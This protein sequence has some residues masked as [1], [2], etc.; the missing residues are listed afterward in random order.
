M[1]TIDSLK[2]YGAD[3]NDG[4]TRCMNNESFY[5]MLVGKVLADK[6]LEQLEEQLGNKDYNGAFES[7]HALKGMYSNLSLTPLTKP[8]SEMTELLRN[9]TDTDYSELLKETKTQFE[10]LKALSV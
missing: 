3:V 1:I 8:I 5:L 4:L 2:K 6:R 9:R 7:A 10:T